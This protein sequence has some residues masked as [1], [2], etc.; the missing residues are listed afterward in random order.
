MSSTPL[1]ERNTDIIILLQILAGELISDMIHRDPQS[2]PPAKCIGN[3]P[4]FWTDQKILAFLQDVSD[5]VE[6]LQF[7]V[8][9]LKSL[10][11]NGNIVVLDD[12]NIHLDPII[13]EDLRKFRGYMGASVRDL[14]RALRNKV[15]LLFETFSLKIMRLGKDSFY[16][17][18]VVVQVLCCPLNVV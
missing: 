15:R 17:F 11:K 1:A 2:R 12:W 18:V 6:K 14:L 4:I 13:T 10:E 9:P 3:H 16:D 8:E 7:N 5:R